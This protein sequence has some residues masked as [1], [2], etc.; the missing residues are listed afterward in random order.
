[1]DSFQAAW[2]DIDAT[3]KS[4]QQ[5]HILLGTT[6]SMAT[7]PTFTRARRGLRSNRAW[8]PTLRRQAQTPI[9]RK[10]WVCKL[11]QGIY[12]LKQSSRIWYETLTKL[13]RELGFT[14]S[15]WDGGLWFHKEKQVY[16][17]LYVDDV[18]L[19]GPDEAILDSISQQI[20]ARFDIKNLGHNHHYLGMKV[21][22]DHESKTIRLSQEVYAKIY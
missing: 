15:K 17:M 14:P 20:A 3:S 4:P 13:L 16:M 12:G 8:I 22:Q 5:P 21:E 9:S 1:V 11:N 19:V 2:E 18:K 7:G 10:C 6:H